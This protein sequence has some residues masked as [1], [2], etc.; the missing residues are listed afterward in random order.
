MQVFRVE[1]SLAMK[2]L[3]PEASGLGLLGMGFLSRQ[4]D[5]LLRLQFHGADPM[6]GGE[7]GYLGQ[8]PA[9]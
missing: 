9:Q 6:A 4:N 5:V 3:A 7:V 1:R 2:S 8:F